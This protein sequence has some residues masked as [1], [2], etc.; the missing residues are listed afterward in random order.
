MLA[1]VRPNKVYLLDIFWSGI[2]FNVLLESFAFYILIY[3]F[4]EIMHGYVG[5]FHTNQTSMCPHLNEG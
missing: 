4:K 5:V 1:V 2:Q 3:M